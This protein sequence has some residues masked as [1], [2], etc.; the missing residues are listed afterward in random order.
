VVRDAILEQTDLDAYE[1]ARETE[2]A[3]RLRV[4]GVRLDRCGLRVVG[5]R[6]EQV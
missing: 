1:E 2:R 4:L 6:P 5:C 3:E